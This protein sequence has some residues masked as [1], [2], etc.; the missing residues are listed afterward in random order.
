VLLVRHPLYLGWLFAL[1]DANHASGPPGFCHGHD[2][3]HL[4]GS[5]VK[6][7]DLV[8]ASGDEYR[9]YQKRGPMIVPVRVG[10]TVAA[11]LPKLLRR[12][13]NTHGVFSN[14]TIR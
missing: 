13:S 5:Q 6:E 12:R 4:S 3:V 9:R 14:F 11:E 8:D 10:K 7:K 1:V 2:C